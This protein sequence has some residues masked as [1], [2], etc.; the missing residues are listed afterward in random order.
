MQVPLFPLATVLFPEGRLDL[1]IFEV[2]YLDMIGRCWRSGDA[3][4]VCLL[5]RGS[6]V[7]RAGLPDESF[8][9]YGTLALIEELASPRPGLMLIR[10]RGS[11][12]FKIV[13][14]QK[15]INGA[16]SAAIEPVADDP[17]I[18]IP[19]HLRS[20]AAG[21]KQVLARLASGPDST[22]HSSPSDWQFNDAAWVANRWSE[23]LPLDATVRQ[24]LLSLDNPLIRLELVTDLLRQ[25]SPGNA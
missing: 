15:G 21:L 19:E 9:P 20:T 7:R 2:R 12:R 22:Q 13:G 16:W 6:E 17:H 10:C 25:A 1:Q 24:Q 23:L 8:H 18:T 14:S 3:F 5:T 11:T 4:G